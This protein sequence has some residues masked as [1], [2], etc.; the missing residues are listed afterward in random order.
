MPDTH[1]L[2]R[3]VQQV[4]GEVRL[5]RAEF[6]GLRGLFIGAIAAAVPLLV[7]ERFGTAAVVAA[8]AL[9]ITGGLIGALVGY[10]RR[11]SPGE[12]ARLADRGFGLQDR[13]ATAL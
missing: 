7:R 6:W 5:R 8:G 10:M 3:L 4:V 2:H 12:A 11:V 1:V 13:V 9:L